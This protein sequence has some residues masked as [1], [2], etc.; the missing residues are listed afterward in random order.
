MD[1]FSLFFRHCI[2]SDEVAQALRSAQFEI[3]LERSDEIHVVEGRDG[4]VWIGLVNRS[5][6]EPEELA[7][8]H[9]WPLPENQV[10]A[11][12][13]ITVRRNDLSSQLAVRLAYQLVQD[14]GGSISWGGMFYWEQLYNAH[15][16]AQCS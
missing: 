11:R 13:I 12:A 14:F 8:S 15:A 2:R 4:Y 1:S 7:E 5:E 3:K 9:L 16:A 6:F 10:G